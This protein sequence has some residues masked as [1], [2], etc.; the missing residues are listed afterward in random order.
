MGSGAWSKCR[1]MTHIGGQ[2]NID[3][4]D[5]NDDS[6][7]HLDGK[8]LENTVANYPSGPIFQITIGWQYFPEFIGYARLKQKHQN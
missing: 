6:L 7:N 2:E 3:T 1:A 8:E 5:G 4:L